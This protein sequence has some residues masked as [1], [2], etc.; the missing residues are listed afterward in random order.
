MPGAERD[1]GA[2]EAVLPGKGE[3]SHQVQ[4]RPVPDR[5][6]ELVA[7]WESLNDQLRNLGIRP[8]TLDE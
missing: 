2:A 6:Q 1:N 5:L 4:G 8:L 3:R 7:Y